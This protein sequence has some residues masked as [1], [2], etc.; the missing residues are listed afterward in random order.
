M[1]QAF[2]LQGLHRRSSADELLEPVLHTTLVRAVGGAVLQL[3][4]TKHIWSRGRKLRVRKGALNTITDI[5]KSAALTFC[6][7]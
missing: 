5:C 2:L 6:R 7:I 3:G 1:N 4:A